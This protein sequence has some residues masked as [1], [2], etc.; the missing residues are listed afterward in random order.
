MPTGWGGG[1]GGTAGWPV[2]YFG[3]GH[4]DTDG[5]NNAVANQVIYAGLALGYQ[6]KANKLVL[7]I[8]A[9]DASHNSDFGI[10]NQA[11]NS[12]L[13]NIG[14]QTIGSTGFQSFALVQGTVTFNPGLYIFAWT[15]TAATIGLGSAGTL[16]V[17]AANVSG[18][19]TSSGGALPA[20]FTA[21]TVG[22]T[23]NYG[24][25]FALLFS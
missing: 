1:G 15:S 21:P 18:V 3:F 7:K 17:W 20:S 23:T 14:A 22:F 25:P 10:Y 2:T 16:P 6:L 24:W 12:L 5:T 4:V 19:G 13:A 8:A 11:A 9:A